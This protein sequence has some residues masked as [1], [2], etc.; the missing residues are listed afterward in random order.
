[1]CVDL[2]SIHSLFTGTIPGQT[3]SFS[4]LH[5]LKSFHDLLSIKL[6]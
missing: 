6:G 1:V 2:K 4:E 3:S 5:N